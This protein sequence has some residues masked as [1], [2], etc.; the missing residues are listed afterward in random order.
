MHVHGGFGYGWLLYI[1]ISENNIL[2]QLCRTHNPSAK[3][4]WTMANNTKPVLCHQLEAMALPPGL[5][6]L[7]AVV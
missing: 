1:Y 7:S 4:E 6:E 5:P 2:S 3:I